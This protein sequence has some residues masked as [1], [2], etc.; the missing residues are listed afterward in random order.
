MPKTRSRPRSPQSWEA[1]LQSCVQWCCELVLCVCTQEK[2]SSRKC[3]FMIKEESTGQMLVKFL[4]SRYFSIKIHNDNWYSPGEKWCRL[5]CQRR[6]HDISKISF[7]GSPF[8]YVV[9]VTKVKSVRNSRG[10]DPDWPE[11]FYPEHEQNKNNIAVVLQFLLKFSSVVIFCDRY[12][13][14]TNVFYSSILWWKVKCIMMWC[15]K[16]NF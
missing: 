12:F 11:Y 7:V 16:L 6:I 14:L 13:G 10:W 2:V 15:E 5:K 1:F 9:L 3:I 8:I 4:R